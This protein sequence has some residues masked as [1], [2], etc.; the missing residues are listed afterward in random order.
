MSIEENAKE[1]LD[2]LRKSGTDIRWDVPMEFKQAA[3]RALV[4]LAGE[5][6]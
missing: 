3:A 1:I 4:E 5:L 2:R 6:E